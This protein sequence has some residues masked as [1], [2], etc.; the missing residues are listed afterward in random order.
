MFEMYE[1]LIG[2]IES[3]GAWGPAGFICLYV[4]GCIMLLPGFPLTCGAGLIFGFPLGALYV[5]CGVT[6]GAASTFGL[7]RYFSDWL[8]ARLKGSSGAAYCDRILE[9]GGWRAVALVR[10]CPIFP[11]RLCNYLFGFSCISFRQFLL[12]TWLG[13]LPS[14]LTYTAL[15]ATLGNFTE[16]YISGRSRSISS[17][18]LALYVVGSLFLIFVM[19]LSGRR[20]AQSLDRGRCLK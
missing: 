9:S 5:S 20:A 1:A 14:V 19:V 18:Y 17:G 11:F 2:W 13:T 16:I 10:L 4:I 3:L 8:P 12:G 15:G 7:V 6:L